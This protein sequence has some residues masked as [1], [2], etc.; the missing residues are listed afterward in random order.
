MFYRSVTDTSYRQFVLDT[1]ITNIDDY[2]AEN[3]CR[4]LVPYKSP[5]K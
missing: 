4:D 5:T 1:Q 3:Q 2:I